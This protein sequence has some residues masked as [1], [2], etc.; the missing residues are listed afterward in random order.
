MPIDTPTAATAA[1]ALPELSFN[2]GSSDQSLFLR[3]MDEV[4][5]ARA[6][7]AREKGSESESQLQVPRP[8]ETSIEKITLPDG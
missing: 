2:A 7:E 6:G 5:P 1:D 3:V 8:G 4:R